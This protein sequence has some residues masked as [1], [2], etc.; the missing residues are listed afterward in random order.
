MKY[1]LFTFLFL[2]SFNSF[3]QKF[4]GY[5]HIAIMDL[6]YNDGSLDKY[7]IMPRIIKFFKKKGIDTV[8]IDEDSN[9]YDGEISYITEENDCEILILQI[10]HSTPKTGYRTEVQFKFFDCNDKLMKFSGSGYSV[11]A[12]ADV[13]N[14]VKKILKILDKRIGKYKFDSMKTPTIK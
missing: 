8:R 9:F 10:S 12:K 2:I 14:G 6:E 4:N 11:S 7:D 3:G 13:N 1:T 5:S